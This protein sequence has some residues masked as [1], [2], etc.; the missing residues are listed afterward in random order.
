VGPESVAAGFIAGDDL[1]LSGSPNL[2]LAFLISPMT[3]TVARAGTER[4][5]GGWP[6]P[7]PRAS[8]QVRQLNSIAT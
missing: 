1:G 7:T 6:G 4:I 8:F 3:A 2:N 5:L